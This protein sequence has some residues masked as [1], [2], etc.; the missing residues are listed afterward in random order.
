M[1]MDK[2]G[3]LVFC[4][5]SVAGGCAESIGIVGEDFVF[6]LQL[7]RAVLPDNWRTL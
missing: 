2:C 7:I 4:F 5:S 3:G 1:I 6:P